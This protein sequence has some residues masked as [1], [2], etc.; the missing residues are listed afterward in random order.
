MEQ[1]TVESITISQSKVR[2]LNWLIDVSG[3]IQP[4]DS[5]CSIIEDEENMQI[6]KLETRTSETLFVKEKKRTHL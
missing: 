3:C 4:K 1:K 6:F 5:Q 2:S